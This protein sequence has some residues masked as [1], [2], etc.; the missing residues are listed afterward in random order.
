MVALPGPGA[1]AP[2]HLPALVSAGLLVALAVPAL[3]MQTSLGGNEDISARDLQ[4]VQTYDRIQAAFPSE[5][6]AEMV[7]VKADDVTSTAV[8][9]AIDSLESKAAKA[10]GLFEGEA[11]V[12]MSSD[13]TV[14]MVTLPTT[15][16]NDDRSN[17][18]VDALRDD[19]VPPPSASLTASRLATGEAAATGV[20]ST[21]R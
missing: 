2:A 13:Q 9:S 7:V 5:D 17:R 12:E 3:G 16:T 14:A 1:A 15:G 4:V 11:T 18:A 6:G 19:L 20:T 10:P 8:V 21:T